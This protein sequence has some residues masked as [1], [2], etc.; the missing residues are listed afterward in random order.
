MII[1]SKLTAEL[2]L[3]FVLKKFLKIVTLWN[4]SKPL[5]WVDMSDLCSHYTIYLVEL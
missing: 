5:L 4:E 1:N 3:V 2:E